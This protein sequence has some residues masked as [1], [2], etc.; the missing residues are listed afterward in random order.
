MAEDE[1][2]EE[3]ERDPPKRNL[4]EYAAVGVLGAAYE[5]Q[6]RKDLSRPALPPLPVSS[7][8]S[9]E[10]TRFR[11]IVTDIVKFID[12]TIS[13]IR[14]VILVDALNLGTTYTEFSK[15][16]EVTGTVAGDDP[17]F[18]LRFSQQ[19][20]RFAI[21]YGYVLGAWVSLSVTGQVD[22]G[23]TIEEDFASEESIILRHC[24]DQTDPTLANARLFRSQTGGLSSHTTWSTHRLLADT[25]IYVPVNG[26][27][28]LIASGGSTSFYIKALN[29]GANTLSASIRWR[30]YREETV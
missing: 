27:F 10:R 16:A 17:E 30:E 6:R 11:T 20:G 25:P 24:V 13:P 26:K 22:V 9:G 23:T 21:A 1:E 5:A 19:P 7:P 3:E 14:S 12:I 2:E 15:L 28:P 4:L 18:L 8:P 29:L